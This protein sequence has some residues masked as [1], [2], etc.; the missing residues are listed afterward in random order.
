[1]SETASVAPA[2]TAT[3]VST[4]STAAAPGTKPAVKPTPKPTKPGV[5]AT[6]KPTQKPAEAAQTQL[7]GDGSA[8]AGAEKAEAKPPELYEVTING[9]KEKWTRE[10]VL[11][12][13]QKSSAAQ[14]RFRESAEQT[15][16]VQRM[17]EML[18]QDPLAV[19]AERGIDIDELATKRLASKAE[20]ALMT[21]EQ[22]ELRDLRAEVERG[23]SEKAKQ[24]E[25]QEAE[26]LQVQTKALEEHWEKG[27]IQAAQSVGLETTPDGLEMMAAAA[28]ELNELLGD[29]MNITFEM[30]AAEAKDKIDRASAKLET[31]VAGGLQGEQLLSFLGPKTVEAVLQA[32]LAK[33][34]GAP[35]YVGK[36]SAVEPAKPADRKPMSIVEFRKAHGY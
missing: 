14:E 3:P 18:D 5:Q 11:A 20:D 31:R 25:A 27:F 1:M 28:V 34:K 22:R 7:V 35:A 15:K 21:P 12:E 36:P 17:L 2:A 4:D 16:K 29:K 33:L 26:Q 24:L 8:D 13:A 10:K 23:K 32:S 19:L 30:V 9:K 6:P